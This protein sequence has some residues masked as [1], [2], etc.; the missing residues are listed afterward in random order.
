[1]AL[2]VLVYYLW[3]LDLHNIIYCHTEMDSEGWQ[4]PIGL[5]ASDAICIDDSD[6]ESVGGKQPKLAP[7]S[8]ATTSK[9]NG[10]NP[11]AIKEKEPQ[12]ES[13]DRI[14]TEQNAIQSSN[15][16]SGKVNPFASFAFEAAPAEQ[17]NTN[18]STKCIQS[19]NRTI[20][21][22]NK[23]PKLSWTNK[24]KEPM[25]P[26]CETHEEVTEE[27]IS[28][29][30]SFARATDSLE[31]Q[32]F[33]VLIAARLHARC[34]EA[35]VR[36]AMSKLHNHFESRDGLNARAL[37]EANNEEIAPLLSSVLFGNTKA[38]QIV[39]AAQDIVKMGGEVP[40]TKDKLQK[41]AGIG[42]TL[43]SI[44]SRVNTRASYRQKRDIRSQA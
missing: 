41:I 2:S 43:A 5:T 21:H 29:W 1:M 39:L 9:L 4:I 24:K 44:L 22:V 6:F 28:K 7:T 30:H 38:K 37:S 17:L 19:S 31:V 13:A 15:D 33:H 23:K 16:V 12:T 34:H 36:K 20:D 10:N 3:L 27:C 42:P 40:E 25:M 35:T 26:Q 14:V 18:A 32:R 8:S 11:N